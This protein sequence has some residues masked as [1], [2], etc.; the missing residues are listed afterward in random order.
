PHRT[1]PAGP[2]DRLAGRHDAVDYRRWR[3]GRDGRAVRG[4]LPI[5][6]AQG[7]AQVRGFAVLVGVAVAAWMVFAGA[8]M[9]LGG[10]GPEVTGPA[11]L[12]CLA[13]N[14]LALGVVELVRT[15][16]EY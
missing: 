12:V 4:A 3:V 11:L 8:A 1:S 10:A 6:T 7:A 2:V 16:S 13:P 5:R 14:L 9:L 15:R